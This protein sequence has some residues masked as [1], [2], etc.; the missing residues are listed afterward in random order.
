LPP[1]IEYFGT[2]TGSCD[3]IWD[4]FTPLANHTAYLPGVAT[5]AESGKDHEALCAGPFCKP[6]VYHWIGGSDLRWEVD[7]YADS[8]ANDTLH[9]VYVR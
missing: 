1:A 7:D 9:R 2:G 4:S 8:P 3:G 6:G 5:Q